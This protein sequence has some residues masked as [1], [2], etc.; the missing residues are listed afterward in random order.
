MESLQSISRLTISWSVQFIFLS[1]SIHQTG[2]ECFFSCNLSENHRKT[3]GCLFNKR[4][5]CVGVKNMK[6]TPRSVHAR[7]FV[8]LF[9]VS[10][11]HSR[12][13][14]ST[15]RIGKVCEARTLR[16]LMKQLGYRLCL[17]VTKPA[18]ESPSRRGKAIKSVEIFRGRSSKT[19][20]IQIAADVL[21]SCLGGLKRLFRS[22]NRF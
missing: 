22:R 6:I 12:H 21:T 5:Q 10:T 17:S 14:K 16:N 4:F 19:F 8:S 13:H 2:I 20:Q 18:E 1:T 9:D 15:Q 3:K 11:N 7:N